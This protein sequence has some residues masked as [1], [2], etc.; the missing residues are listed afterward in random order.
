MQLVEIKHVDCSLTF[1]LSSSGLKY[2]GFAQLL[3]IQVV[4]LKM[5]WHKL[6]VVVMVVGG[7]AE[8]FKVMTF[9]TAV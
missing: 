7:H 3:P 4:K 2:T 5:F 9:S 1:K 8:F 6:Y